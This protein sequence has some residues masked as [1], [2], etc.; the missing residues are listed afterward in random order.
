MMEGG[1]ERNIYSC[2]LRPKLADETIGYNEIDER[3]REREREG[4][5]L[6]N[7]KIDSHNRCQRRA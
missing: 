1:R 7:E 2:L 6:D 5:D 3:E 4:S